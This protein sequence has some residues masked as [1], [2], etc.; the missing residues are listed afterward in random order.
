MKIIFNFLKKKDSSN[1]ETKAQ[2][3]GNKISDDSTKD[4]KL[5]SAIKDW[6]SH[7]FGLAEIYKIKLDYSEES[8]IKVEE[9]SGIVHDELAAN[10]N[11]KDENVE[12][13]AKM[14]GS[15]L[16]EVIIKYLGGKWIVDKNNEIAI[17]IKGI[18]ENKEVYF[19]FYPISKVL[20]RLKNGAEDDLN[21]YYNVIKSNK[22]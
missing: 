4:E 2:N 12:K 16:G 11:T 22:K 8:I 9:L 5:I 13:V 10:P 3:N 21:L 14:I 17:Q 20:K 1:D 18:Y 7:V 19:E 15:Y 6:Q